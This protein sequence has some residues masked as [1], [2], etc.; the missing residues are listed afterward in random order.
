VKYAYLTVSDSVEENL[1]IL[2]VHNIR[3]VKEKLKK[4]IKKGTGLEVTIA[5]LRKV[6]AAGV[7]KW[8]ESIR[9]LYSFCKLSKCQLVLSSGAMSMNE[10]ASGPSLDAILKNCNIE[11]QGHWREINSWLEAKLSRRVSI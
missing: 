9:D 11:P 1:D 7:G 2:T 5:P 3:G 6:D 10:M 4:R 8:F